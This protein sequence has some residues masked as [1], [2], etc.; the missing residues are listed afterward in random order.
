MTE[1]TMYANK[2]GL[3]LW[4]MP[5]NTFKQTIRTCQPSTAAKCSYEDTRTLSHLVTYAKVT[6][7]SRWL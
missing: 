4:A 7:H 5:A 1:Q 6:V 2:H 3:M